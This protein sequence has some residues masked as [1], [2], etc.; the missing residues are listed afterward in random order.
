MKKLSILLGL[1][2]ITFSSFAKDVNEE[3]LKVF[4]NT[5]PD[6]KKVSWSE[7]K[8]SYMVFFTKNNISFRVIYDTEGNIVMAFKYYGEDNL[9][10]LV[11]GKVKK[12]Y[13]DFSVHSVVEKS[14]EAA[15]EYH[16][17]LENSK[18]L[19]TLKADPQGSFQVESKYNKA[20]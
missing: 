12:A 7:D 15:I 18:K 9:P 13:P 16:I 8:D 1:L 10:P 19:V 11:L 17:T 2:A 4:H 5:Y 20:D 14:S 3:V 6:A